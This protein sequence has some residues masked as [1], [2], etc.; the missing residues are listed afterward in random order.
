[1]VTFPKDAIKKKIIEEQ[2][3][4]LIEVL[5]TAVIMAVGLLAMAQMQVITIKMNAQ[6]RS[7]TEATLLAMGQLEYLKSLPFDAPESY[8]DKKSYPLKDDGSTSDLNDISGNPDHVHPDYPIDADGYPVNSTK[9]RF[10][11]FWNV[12]DDTPAG[13]TGGNAKTVAVTVTW[14]S[15]PKQLKKRVTIPTVIRK[16]S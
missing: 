11:V 8:P 1:M 13:A 6:N 5:I 15:G 4:T 14:F 12:A 16:E 3:F 9:T 7:V 2:G 10:G